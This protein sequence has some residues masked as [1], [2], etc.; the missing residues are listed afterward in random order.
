MKCKLQISLLLLNLFASVSTFINAAVAQEIN[1]NYQ[2]NSDITEREANF[3]KT[4]KP[5][6]L[7][8]ELQAFFRSQYHYW[9]A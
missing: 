7:N 4:P 9:D 5:T 2:S 3:T 8:K 6:G 1:E